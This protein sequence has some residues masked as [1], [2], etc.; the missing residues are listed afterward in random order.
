MSSNESITWE[1]GV[2]DSDQVEDLDHFGI[3]G[4]EFVGSVRDKK[5]WLIMKRPGLSFREQV[6][7]DQRRKYFAS[8]D[9]DIDNLDPGPEA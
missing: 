7:L 1:Y 2:L 4:W 3:A 6:T 9:I 5:T 8:W